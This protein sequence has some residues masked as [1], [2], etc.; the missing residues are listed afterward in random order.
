[1]YHVKHY[2]IRNSIFLLIRQIPFIFITYNTK[3]ECFTWNLSNTLCSNFFLVEEDHRFYKLCVNQYSA[4]LSGKLQSPLNPRT[5]WC[6]F[7]DVRGAGHRTSIECSLCADRSE[8]ETPWIR[9][10]I[11]QLLLTR[12]PCQVSW[13]KPEFPKNTL[14]HNAILINT[15]VSRETVPNSFS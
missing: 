7:H 8:S 4:C 14:F 13:A 9:F 12:T 10:G 3:R 15:H 6:T 1:M 2:S 11:Y 5:P